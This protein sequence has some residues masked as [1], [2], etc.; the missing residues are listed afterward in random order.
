MRFRPLA[1]ASEG[2]PYATITSSKRRSVNVEKKSNTQNPPSF[3]QSKVQSASS[4]NPPVPDW[5]QKLSQ[6][7]GQA[8]A[9]AVAT[10][11]PHKSATT[12][13]NAPAI[14]NTTA[15][16]IWDGPGLPRSSTP[17]RLPRRETAGNSVAARLT[18]L[19][20]WRPRKFPMSD[21]DAAQKSSQ[22]ISAP[23][24]YIGR[25][26]HFEET[27]E[28]LEQN[29]EEEGENEYQPTWSAEEDRVITDFIQDPARQG[30]TIA[31]IL[32]QFPDKSLA[33]LTARESFLREKVASEVPT[34]SVWR[35][36]MISSGPWSEEEDRILIEFIESPNWTRKRL[37][38][39]LARLPAR[40]LRSVQQREL[41]MR[42]K[43]RPDLVKEREKA[44]RADVSLIYTPS[45][46][47]ASEPYRRRSDA[48]T[49]KEI[50]TGVRLRLDQNMSYD[51]IAALLPGRDAKSVNT[52]YKKWKGGT[53]DKFLQRSS[54]QNT[55]NDRSQSHNEAVPV[56]SST[57]NP[58]SC[59][60]PMNNA[61]ET[62]GIPRVVEDPTISSHYPPNTQTSPAR[63]RKRD[64]PSQELSGSKPSSR[65]ATLA[66][67]PRSAYQGPDSRQEE[68]ND[69]QNPGRHLQMPHPTPTERPRN[70]KAISNRQ[71]L[72]SDTRNLSLAKPTPH[73]RKFTPTDTLKSRR[74][75]RADDLEDEL[76]M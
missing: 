67:T 55:Q 56:A 9:A 24:R 57:S 31:A 52:M 32:A 51:A 50:R 37:P 5:V 43:L 59:S 35:Q 68:A 72:G 48:W 6:E 76:A 58:A 71:A 42:R 41:A 64:Q 40:N 11:L 25:S 15:R 16:S 2:G 17:R 13:E 74:R 54:L 53:Y 49:A 34:P 20:R 14:Q 38:D 62:G 65:L 61:A 63:K 4:A 18:S 7:I 36:E 66:K 30:E 27:V 70:D 1:M 23:E 21:Q 73:Q 8:V 39:L 45:P 19:D 3:E 33:D 22:R 26:A 10:N 28:D 69:S 46:E 60:T 29:N 47:A 44:A 75:L 12:E